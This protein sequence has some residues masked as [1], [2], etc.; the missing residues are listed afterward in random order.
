MRETHSL[1]IHIL[2]GRT[3]SGEVKERE[4]GFRGVTKRRQPGRAV[5]S[6]AGD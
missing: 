2:R 3:L 6:I 4:V 1:P 5:S